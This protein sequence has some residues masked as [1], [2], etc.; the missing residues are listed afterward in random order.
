MR[1]SPEAKMNAARAV[2]NAWDAMEI[3]V[4]VQEH[5]WIAILF[6]RDNDARMKAAIGRGR[7]ALEAAW[8]EQMRRMPFI[9]YFSTFG[10]LHLDCPQGG[11]K[12][13]QRCVALSLACT[14]NRVLS[15]EEEAHA[16]ARFREFM[17]IMS[18]PETESEKALS[19]KG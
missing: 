11:C 17:D 7:A 18:K 3:S 15:S 13:A 10:L 9:R 16:L 4:A 1:T 6:A 12:R 2:A 14:H 19:G 8:A 5:A